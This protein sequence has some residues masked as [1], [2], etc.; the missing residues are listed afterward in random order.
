LAGP[1]GVGKSNIFDAIHFLSLLADRPLLEAAL[2]V[3]GA[4]PETADPADLFWTVGDKRAEEIALEAEMLL[5]GEVFDDF[6]REASASKV[7][8][9]CDPACS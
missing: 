3:R 7:R 2:S 5:D 9:R 4:E 1:T 6:G 8:F